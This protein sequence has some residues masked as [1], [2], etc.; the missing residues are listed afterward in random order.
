MQATLKKA[1]KDC[2]L[3]LVRIFLIIKKRHCISRQIPKMAHPFLQPGSHHH[4]QQFPVFI[5]Q[6]HRNQFTFTLTTNHN[7]HHATK[8]TSGKKRGENVDFG[9]WTNRERRCRAPSQQIT[10]FTA[11]IKINLQFTCFYLHFLYTLQF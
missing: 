4:Q 6:F 9:P 7:I 10:P 2:D 1:S 3:K 5:T 8:K 11:F